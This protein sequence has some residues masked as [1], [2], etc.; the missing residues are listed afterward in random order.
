MRKNASLSKA[1][2]AKNDEF[3]TQLSDTEKELGHYEERFKG[4]NDIPKNTFPRILIR[5]RQTN[6]N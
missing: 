6:G 5:R 1:K 3:C 4:V 2:S